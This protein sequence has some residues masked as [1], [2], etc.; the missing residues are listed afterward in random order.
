[1]RAGGSLVRQPFTWAGEEIDMEPTEAAEYWRV[2][3][4]VQAWPSELRLALAEALLHS[5]H[6]ELHPNGS[7]GVP[8]E[9]MLGMAAGKGPP[10][11][12]ATI[13]QWIEEYRLRK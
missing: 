2:L 12:D 7:R 11:S 5:L 10:P 13:K 1:L 8:V 4:K 6:R 3:E 9:K